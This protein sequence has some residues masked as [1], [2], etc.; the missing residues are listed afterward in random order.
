MLFTWERAHWKTFLWE[1]RFQ[2]HF[3][4]YDF[5]KKFCENKKVLDIACGSGYGTNI[6]SQIAKEIIWM[7]VSKDAIKFNK[8][9]YKLNNWEFIYYDWKINPFTNKTFDVIISFETIEHI[10]EYN[11][12]LK[13]LK[14]VLKDNWIL[15]ISTP[16]F[17]GEIWKNKYHVSN[18]KHEKFIEI[19]G[20][21]FN[22]EKIYYQWK[23]FYPF[24]W[25]GVIESL[26]WIKRDINIYWEKPD[27]EHHVSIL[28][29]KK[30]NND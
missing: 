1:Q 23:H 15:I 8:N 29:C 22:I 26:F 5:A 25:R 3:I 19:V 14:R 21:Y 11:N 13:E 24:P 28:F 18:F 2:D 17:L 30:T 12:F 7:D 16:N 9:T 6:L 20:K 27:F 4:R 10:V